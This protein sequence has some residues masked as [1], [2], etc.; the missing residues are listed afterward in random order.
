MCAMPEN[1]TTIIN[2]IRV[3]VVDDHKVVRVG[4]RAMISHEPDMEVVA[5]AGNAPEALAAHATFQPDVTLVDLR[6]PDISGAELITQ[7]RQRDPK[8]RFIILTSYDAD[9]D[10][11]RAIQAGAHGYLLKG[12]FPEGILEEAIRTVHAGQRVI[13]PEIAQRLA[14]RL[15]VPALTPREIAV[16]ELVAKGLSNR[17]IGAALS[18]RPGTVK[19]H[20]ERIYAKLGVGD[21]TAAALTAIQRGLVSL[22]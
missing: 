5:E 10:V 15:S 3:L 9:E 22:H 7:I 17:E 4:L 11:F 14:H 13:P 2:K 8:A 21:R 12:T 1:E 6:L 20:L 16:L 18:T 19:T